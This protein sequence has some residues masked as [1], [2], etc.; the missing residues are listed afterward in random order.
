MKRILALLLFLAAPLAAQPSKYRLDTQVQPGFGAT[1]LGDLFYAIDSKT[2]ARLPHATGLQCLRQ[3]GSAPPYWEP[4]TPDWV[5]IVSYGADPAASAATNTTAIRAAIAAAGLRGTVYVPQGVYD[6]TSAGSE[7][8]LITQAIRITAAPGA[9]FRVTSGTAGTVDVI[10]F[11]PTTSDG[12]FGFVVDG[13]SIQPQSGTPGRHALVLDATTTGIMQYPRVEH[14]NF[15]GLSGRSIV[16]LG[17]SGT[18]SIFGASVAHNS[19]NRGINLIYA[20]DS[21]VFAEN[22]FTGTT[23]AM[24]GGLTNGANQLTI[25]ENNSTATGGFSFTSIIESCLSFLRNNVELMIGDTFAGS[26]NAMVNFA[27]AAGGIKGLV[28]VG[29]NIHIL[30]AGSN[31]DCMR[32]DYVD[33]ALVGGANKFIDP[34][35]SVGIVTTAHAARVTITPENYCSGAAC[36]GTFP[37]LSI[38]AGSTTVTPGSLLFAGLGG[39]TTQDAANAF[40]DAANHYLCLGCT[41]P[42]GPLQVGANYST[43]PAAGTAKM[44]VNG[45]SSDGNIVFTEYNHVNGAQFIGRTAAGTP[46]ATGNVANTRIVSLAAKAFDGSVFPAASIGLAAFFAEEN[47]T[48]TAQGTYYDVE[49]TPT[50]STGAARAK[51]MRVKANGDVYVGEG[52]AAVET[53]RLGGVIFTQTANSTTTANTLTTLFGTGLPSS[54]LT[55]PA[56]LLSAGRSIEIEMGGYVSAAD[57]AVGTKTLTITLGGTTVATGTSLATFATNLNTGWEAHITITCRTAG[58]PGTVQA[59]GVWATQGVAS[60]GHQT[61]HA[62]STAA[63]N[64]TTTGTLVLDATWNNGNATGTIT[65]TY[66]NVKGN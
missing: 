13:L 11:A 29:N 28:A 10:R 30:P 45:A 61:V 33:T 37:S 39:V 62:T 63:T 42:V 34:S 32:L 64:I 7:I 15:G 54:G 53:A 60:G 22:V 25:R 57:G 41:V 59:G 19:F 66:A 17:S 48:S 46:G 21:N 8:F 43:D 23:F 52:T 27:G 3:N 38:A 44:V 47:T 4:C 58:A 18:N 65:T 31:V 49:T 56:N 24:D 1:A 35:G 14:C 51:R 9:Q 26:N 20:G 50:G 12:A 36:V 6:V 5:N 16:F 40:Y 55:L 2:F